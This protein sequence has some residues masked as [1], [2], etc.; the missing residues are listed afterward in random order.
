MRAFLIGLFYVSI[1]FGYP[2]TPDSH[3]TPG[4]TC[5]PSENDFSEFRYPEKIPY[6]ERHV[7][8]SLKKRVYEVYRIPEQE[9][10][11]YTIDHL[12][13]LSLGGNNR[14]VNLWPEHKKLKAL[15]PKLEIE[16]YVKLRDGKITQDQAIEKIMRAK[17][18]PKSER[19]ESCL[20]SANTVA[21]LQACV[22]IDAP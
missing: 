3:E 22:L 11:Q 15:R 13:P 8:E 17:F 6:C 14:Q 2:M 1:A 5:S 12:V 21:D 9:R 20:R 10:K 7:N 18:H 19:G 16:L 4:D